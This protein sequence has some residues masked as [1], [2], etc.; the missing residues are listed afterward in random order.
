MT[1]PRESTLV[2]AIV[3]VAGFCQACESKS[4]LQTF[5][6]LN[7]FYRLVVTVSGKADGT[8]VK[9]MGDC[10]LLVFPADR[11]QEAISSLRELKPLADEIWSDFDAKCAV[12]MKAHL[13]SVVIGPLGPDNRLDVIG[14]ALNHLFLMPWD[15]QEL[16][17]ELRQHL[18]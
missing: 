1:G 6:T 14:N 18:E 3:D 13:G 8:V 15:G 9:F 12:R 17:A 11:A 16:S 7:E 2:L 10:A 5:N 4:D